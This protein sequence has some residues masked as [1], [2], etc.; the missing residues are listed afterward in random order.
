MSRLMTDNGQRTECEDRARILETEFAIPN[1][2]KYLAAKT[3]NPTKKWLSDRDYLIV[4]SHNLIVTFSFRSSSIMII[5]IM[6]I[7]LS[8]LQVA[9][10]QHC[11]ISICL[12]LLELDKY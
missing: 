8:S 7:S 12:V 11:R 9:L 4:T 1:I 6:I 10:R 5:I 3:G 2:E